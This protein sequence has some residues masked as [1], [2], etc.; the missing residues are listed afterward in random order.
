MIETEAV[1]ADLQLSTSLL[2][3]FFSS[4][5]S[6]DFNKQTTDGSWTPGE[7]AEHLLRLDIAINRILQ[8]PSRSANRAADEKSAN[9]KY[10]FLDLEKKLQAPREIFPS[11]T[12]KDPFSIIGKI[13]SERHKMIEMVQTKDLSE[14]C[15][16]FSH[17]A[18]GE[19][20]RLE[21]VYLSIYHA[22][23]HML[24]LEKFI[25]VD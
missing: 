17:H 16:S 13:R 19:L 4:F 1:I 15:T 14:I 11:D 23:R 10:V 8:G 2:L 20:T 9:I 25:F 6:E 21:W 7:I 24:H 18:F 3:K 12:I 22:E 5:D